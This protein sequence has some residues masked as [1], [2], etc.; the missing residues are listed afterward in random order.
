MEEESIQLLNLLLPHIQRALEIR[1]VIGVAQQRLA[2]AEA[3]VD[4]SATATFL[5][6]R[7]GR[8]LHRNAAAQLMLSETDALALHEGTLVATKACFR[9]PLRKLF[10]DAAGPISS[11]LRAETRALLRTAS[12]RQSPAASAP[13]FSPAAGEPKPLLR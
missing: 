3:M 5:L 10:Q 11:R 7:E 13:R 1:N 2:G 9:E 4:A 12:S 8:V 6:T